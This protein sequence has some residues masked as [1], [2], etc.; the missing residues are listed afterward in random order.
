MKY[1][2]KGYVKLLVEVTVEA[3]N[4]EEAIEKAYDNIGSL[5]CY[6]GNGGTD[7]IV[8]VNDTDEVKASVCPDGEIEYEEAEALEE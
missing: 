7:K 2:V 4:E 5:D 8:G 3:E 1:V 6:C